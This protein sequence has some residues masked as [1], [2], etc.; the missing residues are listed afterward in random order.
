ML[1]PGAEE[2]HLPP[3]VGDGTCVLGVQ[4]AAGCPG[5]T[6]CVEGQTWRHVGPAVTSLFL[7][8]L[9][10]ALPR[11]PEAYMYSTLP[12]PTTMGTQHLT[13]FYQGIVFIKSLCRK[14]YVAE[15]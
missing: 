7:P 8:A 1:T 14:D 12:Q 3:G 13:V 6:H 9:S 11:R 5:R 10:Q 15:M 2:G 4:S